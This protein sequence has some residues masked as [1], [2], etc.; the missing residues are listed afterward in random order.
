MIDDFIAKAILE[1]FSFDISKELYIV[2]GLQNLKANYF[3]L[4]VHFIVYMKP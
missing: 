1:I 2:E 4:Q 3:V